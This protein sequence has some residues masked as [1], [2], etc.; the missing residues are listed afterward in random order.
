MHMPSKHQPSSMPN[1]VLSIHLKIHHST[2]LPLLVSD[3]AVELNAKEIGK[4]MYTPN[5]RGTELW[6]SYSI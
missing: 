1:L 2:L 4:A 3:L 6:I 5:V